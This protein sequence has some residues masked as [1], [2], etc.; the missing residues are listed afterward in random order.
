MMNSDSGPKEIVMKR[1]VRTGSQASPDFHSCRMP[2]NE[3]RWY[4]LVGIR[5]ANGGLEG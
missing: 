1:S 5:H 2:Q 3:S 4:L